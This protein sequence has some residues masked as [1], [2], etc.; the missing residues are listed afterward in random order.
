MALE[1]SLPTL[2]NL[3]R[4]NRRFRR[5]IRRNRDPIIQRPARRHALRRP[6][7]TAEKGKPRRGP[8]ENLRACTNA[9]ARNR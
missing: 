6:A 7:A 2:M 8:T 5:I 4:H 9:T 1:A 3:P